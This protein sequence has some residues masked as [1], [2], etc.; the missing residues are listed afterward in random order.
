MQRYENESYTSGG[1]DYKDQEIMKLN[2][3]IDNLKGILY[4]AKNERETLIG[5]V[6]HLEQQAKV[7]DSVIVEVNKSFD[8]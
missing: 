8:I 5:T 7:Q 1:D 3:D 4:K 6:S 2:T